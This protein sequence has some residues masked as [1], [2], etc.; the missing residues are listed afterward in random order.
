MNRFVNHYVDLNAQV[1]KAAEADAGTS[2]YTK[3]F[4]VGL[5]WLKRAAADLLSRIAAN[6]KRIDAIDLAD[7]CDF[8]A[9]SR[10]PRDLRCR[11]LAIDVSGREPAN[12]TKLKLCV[13]SQTSQA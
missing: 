7:T 13:F 10:M 1:N 12:T 6:R 11:C 5:E 2:T 9:A 3:V 8:F 4:P